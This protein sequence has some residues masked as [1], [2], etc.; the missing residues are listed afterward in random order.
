M[1]L[2]FGSGI[3]DLCILIRLS[4][5]WQTNRTTREHSRNVLWHFYYFWRLAGGIALPTRSSTTF[6]AAV[7]RVAVHRAFAA[8][9]AP[10]GRRVVGTEN[11][12]C[13]RNEHAQRG[14]RVELHRVISKSVLNQNTARV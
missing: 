4:G 11:D 9:A 13:E 12:Y 1:Q 3:V 10:C 6:K 7:Y 14:S 5:F 8:V 2:R